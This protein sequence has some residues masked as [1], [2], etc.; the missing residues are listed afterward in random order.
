MILASRSEYFRAL[1]YGGMKESNQPEIELIDTPPEAFKILLKYVYAGNRYRCILF[2]LYGI[3]VFPPKNNRQSYLP[4][5]AD[6][7]FKATNS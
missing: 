6:T 1:L 2:F 4:G 5:D 3:P 7:L